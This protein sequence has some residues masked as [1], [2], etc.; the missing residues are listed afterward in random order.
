MRITVV[1]GAILLGALLPAAETPVFNTDEKF[2]LV[3]KTINN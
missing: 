1:L 2:C 3:A